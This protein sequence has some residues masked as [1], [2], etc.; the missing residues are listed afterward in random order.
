MGEEFFLSRQYMDFHFSTYIISS[1]VFLFAFTYRKDSTLLK[2]QLTFV[3]QRLSLYIYLDHIFVNSLLFTIERCTDIADKLIVAI[4]HPFAV[5]ALSVF[6]A[7]AIDRI[8][9]R[10]AKAKTV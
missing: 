1:A 9:Y 10:A 4:V 8:K 6:I 5:I 7:W 3:G 2:K